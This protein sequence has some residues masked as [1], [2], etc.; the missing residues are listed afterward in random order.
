MAAARIAWR[1]H[2]SDAGVRS[3]TQP[4]IAPL[5]QS[6][7]VA[8]DGDARDGEGDQKVENEEPTDR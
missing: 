2:R 6:T 7:D 3:I 8:A 1:F 4:T 5:D